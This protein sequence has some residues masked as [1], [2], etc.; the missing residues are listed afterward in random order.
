M[1]GA[2]QARLSA[3]LARTSALLACLAAPLALL[4]Q[5]AKTPAPTPEQIP[6]LS[7]GDLVRLSAANE[8]TAADQREVLHLFRSRKQTPK[9]SQTRIYVET[10]DA[11]AAMLVALNDQPLTAPQQQAETDHLAWLMNDPD[12]LHK[13]RAREKEDEER[14]LRIVKALPDAFLYEY[15]GAESVAAG[16]GE[17]GDHLAKLNFKPNPAYSPPSR[18]EQVLAGMQGYLLIDTKVR[19]IARIDGTLF[20]EVSFGWG[21]IGHLDQGGHFMVQ[22]ADLGLGDG[23]WG[24]TEISLNV[25]GKLLLFKSLKMVTDEV[26]SDFRKLPGNLTFAQAV[27]MLKTEQEKLAHQAHPDQVHPDQ[28]TDAQKTPR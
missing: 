20:R 12:Q 11:L 22:Q 3:R 18:V 15:A 19:R 16:L 1:R 10:T 17:A 24:I 27:E 25:T 13:K 7:A 4:A 23:A 9:G 14:T 8:V 21:I 26:L 6:E 2:K 5:D 28:A